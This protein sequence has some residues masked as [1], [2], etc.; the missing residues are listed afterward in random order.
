MLP[1]NSTGENGEFMET[2]LLGSTAPSCWIDIKSMAVIIVHDLMQARRAAA[3]RN[4]IYGPVAGFVDSNV[5]ASLEIL[6]VKGGEARRRAR[7]ASVKTGEEAR[8]MRRT[9]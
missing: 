3:R 7:E 2:G 9:M 1:P 4:E 8:A 5:E 6:G